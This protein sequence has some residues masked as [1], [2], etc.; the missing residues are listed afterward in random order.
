MIL[1]CILVGGVFPQGGAVSSACSSVVWPCS[2]GAKTGLWPEVFLL[3][4]SQLTMGTYMARWWFG[5]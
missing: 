2:V 4:L 1:I 3:V 5:T